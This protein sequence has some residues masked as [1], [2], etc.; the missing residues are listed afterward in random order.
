MINYY[1][2]NTLGVV[3]FDDYCGYDDD[4]DEEMNDEWDEEMIYDPIAKNGSKIYQR[5]GDEE[6]LCSFY[7]D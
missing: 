7:D 3:S 1:G 2:G 6:L 4:C 5:N